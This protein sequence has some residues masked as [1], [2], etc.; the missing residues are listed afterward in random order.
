MK[1]TCIA[2]QNSNMNSKMNSPQFAAG[3]APRVLGYVLSRMRLAVESKE[4]GRYE[5]ALI[6]CWWIGPGKKR[7]LEND[8]PMLVLATHSKDLVPNLAPW[9]KYIVVLLLR[10]TFAS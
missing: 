6:C 1:Q 5:P 8:D 9:K 7:K 3:V 10:T 2:I 4:T